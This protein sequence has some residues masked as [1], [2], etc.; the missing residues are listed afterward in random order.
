MVKIDW[1]SLITI[2]LAIFC[3]G[4]LFSGAITS[5]YIKDS[6]I[7]ECY[8]LGF[9]KAS[10]HKSMGVWPFYK[11]P[12]FCCY[13]QEFLTDSTDK[14]HLVDNQKVCYQRF[15]QEIE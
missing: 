12:Q 11:N 9:D 7:L 2:L 4:V 10:I 6:D 8:R 14:A 3:I 15:S 5:R 1:N 13:N